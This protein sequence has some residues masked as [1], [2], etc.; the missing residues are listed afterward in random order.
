MPY[1]SC[2]GSSIS[3]SIPNVAGAADFNSRQK[4]GTPP[5]HASVMMP[6]RVR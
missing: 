1:P 2:Q 4:R 5:T 3:S 6:Y